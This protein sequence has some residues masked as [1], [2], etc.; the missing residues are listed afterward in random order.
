MTLDK[1]NAEVLFKTNKSISQEMEIVKGSKSKLEAVYNKAK[2]KITLALV[3]TLSG[4]AKAK[5]T[6]Y[7]RFDV[8]NNQN[9]RFSD[10]HVE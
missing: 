2:H 10:V 3:R 5:F 8:L 9:L 7:Y 1:L 6:T 4:P